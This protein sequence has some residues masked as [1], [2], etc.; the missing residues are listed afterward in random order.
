MANAA[1]AT[2]SGR[3][4]I[5]NRLKGSGTEPKNL[6]WGDSAVTASAAANVNLFKPQT[7]ARTA[8]TST[9][10]TTAQLADTYQVTGTITAA[11]GA[12]TITEVGLFD[13]TTASPT[14]T[15]AASLTASATVVTI[16]SVSGF[17]TSGN[18]YAQVENETVLVA[19]ANDTTLTITRGRLGSTSAVHAAAVPF[20]IGGDGGAAGSGATSEQTATVNA[21][22][23][24]SGFIHADFAGIALSVNDAINFTIIDQLT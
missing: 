5:W 4:I 20:T 3:S 15:L 8:G 16:G 7:E 18:Y 13:T 10:A 14:T 24:G 11:V 19:G 12:K 2:Y 6:Q 9:L 21:A 1:V 17:P 22:V 23:G